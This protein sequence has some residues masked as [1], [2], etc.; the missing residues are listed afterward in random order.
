MKMKRIY[1]AAL[2][3]LVLLCSAHARAETISK[4]YE[5]EG[6]IT[7]GGKTYPIPTYFPGMEGRKND[8]FFLTI[9]CNKNSDF[10]VYLGLSE[11]CRGE[12]VC[13]FASFL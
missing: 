12:H 10:H 3:C 11:G 6:S 2:I 4:K 1:L 5:G 9:E 7:C 8:G 13:S